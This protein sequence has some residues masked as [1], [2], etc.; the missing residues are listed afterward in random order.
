[1]RRNLLVHHARPLVPVGACC[2]YAV[3]AII[4]EVSCQCN[5]GEVIVEIAFSDWQ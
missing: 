1:M 5:A 3:E 2:G 4:Q